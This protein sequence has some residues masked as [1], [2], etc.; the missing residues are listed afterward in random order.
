M[1]LMSTPLSLTLIGLAGTLLAGCQAGGK[2]EV[3][4]ADHWSDRGFQPRN[5]RRAAVVMFSVLVRANRT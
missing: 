1:R 5:M 4:Q 2:Y 3:W